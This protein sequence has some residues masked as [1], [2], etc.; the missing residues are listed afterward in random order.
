MQEAVTLRRQVFTTKGAYPVAPTSSRPFRQGTK[1]G[2]EKKG[3]EERSEAGPEGGRLNSRARPVIA[4]YNYSLRFRSCG[5][6]RGLG[7]GPPPP[8]IPGQGVSLSLHPP[9]RTPP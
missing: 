2:P 6:C 8:W 7:K 4:H 5:L 3:R 1:Q 9:I